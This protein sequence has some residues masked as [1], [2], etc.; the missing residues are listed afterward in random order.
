MKKLL[1]AIPIIILSCNN[2]Y[3][4][5]GFEFDRY[6]IIDSAW[7]YQPGRRN[8]LETD[9]IYF[10]KTQSGIVICRKNIRID[11]GDTIKV[12]KRSDDASHY[13]F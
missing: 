7:S 11:K 4:E 1:L 5:M 12:M 9:Y 3:E 6:E 8:T 2:N 13:R 10:G